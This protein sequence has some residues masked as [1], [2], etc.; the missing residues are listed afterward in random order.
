MNTEM[1]EFA[2]AVKDLLDTVSKDLFAPLFVESR[3]EFT[4]R[5]SK[6]ICSTSHGL[7]FFENVIAGPD[8]WKEKGEYGD[9]FRKLFS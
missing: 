7:E 5:Y 3:M 4:R 9:N 1:V 6:G 8:K 2:K